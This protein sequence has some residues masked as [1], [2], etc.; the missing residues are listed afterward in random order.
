S[1]AINVS[2]AP[3]SRISPG[4]HTATLRIKSNDPLH[5][6]FNIPLRAFAM[7]GL[8]GANEPSLQRLL[9]LW[10]IPDNVGDDT[11]DESRLPLPPKPPNDE[12]T[13]PK[14]VPAARGPVPATR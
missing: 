5:A 11:P 13:M 8:D 3:S 1:I 7:N 10:Q 9:D 6:N 4:I 12:V 2:F 14:P